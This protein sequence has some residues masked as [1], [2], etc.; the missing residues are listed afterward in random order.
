MITNSIEIQLPY[1]KYIVKCFKIQYYDSYENSDGLRLTRVNFDKF[2]K[3]EDEALLYIKKEQEKYMD[4]DYQYSLYY[5][6]VTHN[7][8]LDEAIEWFIKSMNVIKK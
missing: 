3:T 4:R 5:S 1:N 2:V 8:S 6:H 7:G